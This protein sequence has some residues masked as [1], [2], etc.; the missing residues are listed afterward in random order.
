MHVDLYDSTRNT[1][2]FVDFLARFKNV[3]EGIA[4]EQGVGASMTKI[5]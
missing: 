1:R 4:L 2:L 5:P 3:S